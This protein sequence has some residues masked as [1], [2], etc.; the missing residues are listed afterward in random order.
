MKES[1][2][3]PKSKSKKTLESIV[4]LTRLSGLNK[5]SRSAITND[6]LR[7]MFSLKKP[8]H[9]LF[10]NILNDHMYGIE[11]HQHLFI[12][13]NKRYDLIKT[14][15]YR[16]LRGICEK[17]LIVEYDDGYIINHAIVNYLSDNETRNIRDDL[18]IKIL[19]RMSGPGPPPQ[20]IIDKQKK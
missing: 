2:K 14:H 1:E 12:D 13:T 9:R 15:Y 3:H 8:E 10:L 17:G 4:E 18:K 16:F 7:L 19:P 20:H 6:G 5:Y 11:K